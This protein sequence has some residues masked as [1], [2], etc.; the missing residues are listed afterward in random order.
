MINRKQ[1]AIGTAVI[2]VCLLIIILPDLRDWLR[3]NESERRLSRGRELANVYCSSCHLEP[4]PD[5]LPKQSWQV[6]L[7]YMGYM[8]GMENLD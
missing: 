4:A 7:G 1:I 6:A 5:I 3:E 8:L 2:A